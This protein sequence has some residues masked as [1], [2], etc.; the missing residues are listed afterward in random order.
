[1][2]G[3]WNRRERGSERR[4]IMVRLT[5][6]EEQ[7]LRKWRERRARR[8]QRRAGGLP[9]QGETNRYGNREIPDHEQ[10][11]YGWSQY[12]GQ[13]FARGFH[14]EEY[15]G[16]REA[17]MERG[18]FTGRG[19]KGYQRPDERIF[20]EVCERLTEHGQIDARDISVDVAGGEVILRGTVDSRRTKR[21][22]EDVIET[23]TGVR[24][25]RNELRI[26]QPEASGES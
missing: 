6:E 14:N 20:E 8:W 19:P 2:G 12:Y 25:V 3:D 18:P 10:D 24:D 1:M 7:R 11:E 13:P 5:P 9:L 17:W 21:M 22:V 26:N 23:V 4:E 15:R 16:E